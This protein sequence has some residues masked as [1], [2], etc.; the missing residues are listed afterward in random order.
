[1]EFTNAG[2]PKSTAL[3]FR[4]GLKGGFGVSVSMMFFMRL[5]VA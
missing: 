2:V 4:F 3:F 1:M 5:Q